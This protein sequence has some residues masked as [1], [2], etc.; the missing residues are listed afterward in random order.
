M[1]KYIFFSLLAGA[2]LMSADTLVLRDGSTIDGSFAGGDSRSIR[3][4][5][6]N[7]V[8]TYSLNDVD[9]LRF[10]SDSSSTPTPK[11]NSPAPSGEAAQATQSEQ[12]RMQPNAAANGGDTGTQVPAG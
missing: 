5:V 1:T 2:S 6:G 7:R 9:F 4:T 12:N 10:S 3:F 11:P 8:N